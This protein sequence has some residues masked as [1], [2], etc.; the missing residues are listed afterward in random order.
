MRLPFLDLRLYS[1]PSFH[2]I[3]LPPS[4]FLFFPCLLYCYPTFYYIPLPPSSFDPFP[5]Y[6]APIIHSVTFHCLLPLSFSSLHPLRPFFIPLHSSVSF[7]F[8]YSLP[9]LLYSHH[10]FRYIS[11]PPSC[12]L[13]LFP[14]SSP[15]C[16]TS[17]LTTILPESLCLP[18]RGCFRSRKD[19]NWPGVKLGK[20]IEEEIEKVL[21]K[22]KRGTTLRQ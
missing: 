10:S 16:P 1:H 18:R 6:S 5:A 3:P 2:Y 17:Y 20:S 13:V 14:A 8:P 12:V 22:K 7:I 11:L 9:S 21:E 19:E 15:L 4:S